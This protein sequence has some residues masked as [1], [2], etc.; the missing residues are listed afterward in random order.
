MRRGR[1][2]SPGFDL[3]FSSEHMQI[4]RKFILIE[5]KCIRIL[6]LKILR[7]LIDVSPNITVRLLN[8]M[9]PVAICRQFEDYKQRSFD[10]RLEVS[11]L[12]I[13]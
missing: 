10:E 13:Y 9:Y 1:I 2:Q 12:F 4:M 11:L 6:A 5:E 7:Y 8:K 3:V